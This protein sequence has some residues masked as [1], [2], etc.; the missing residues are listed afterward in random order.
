MEDLA[1]SQS[2]QNRTPSSNNTGKRV[3]AQMPD[4]G[5][6]STRTIQLLANHF[7]VN[8]KETTCIYHYEVTIQSSTNKE[9]SQSDLLTIRNEL[10]KLGI[11]AYDGKRN[12]YSTTKLTTNDFEVIIGSRKRYAVTLKFIKFLDREGLSALPVRR[13]V[14]QS[15]DIIVKDASRLYARKNIILQ[16][17]I[18]LLNGALAIPVFRQTLKYTKQGLSLCVDYSVIPFHRPG[19]VLD[20]IENVLNIDYRKGLNNQEKGVIHQALEGLEVTVTHRKTN[21]KF[22]VHGLSDSPADQ[23][24]FQDAKTN[25]ERKLVKYYEDNYKQDIKYPELPCLDL[26]NG[27]KNY[28]PMEFCLIDEFQKFTKGEM[29][30]EAEKQLRNLNLVS[31]DRR[32]EMILKLIKTKDG[33]CR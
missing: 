21:Q 33:P 20:Y 10:N 15:L 5:G 19:P 9:T 29:R 13:E 25:Q 8:Y 26:S 12:L 11:V 7:L 28:V 3:A 2:Q 27:M 23:I 32:L 22:T 24:T 1:I 6:P 14:L 17:N 16:E 30:P 4:C 18:N 31:P